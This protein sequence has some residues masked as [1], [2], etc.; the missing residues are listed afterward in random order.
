MAAVAAGGS[1]CSVHASSPRLQRMLARTGNG[2][3]AKCWFSKMGLNPLKLWS[4]VPARKLVVRAAQTK[5]KGV[6][7]GFRA[8][9]FQ[10]FL[11]FLYIVDSLV[12][13]LVWIDSSFNTPEWSVQLPEPL[14]GKVWKLEDFESYPALLVNILFWLSQLFSVMNE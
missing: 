7:L 5:S 6:S 14:T 8:P 12:P 1:M 2:F 4:S 10:V 3:I 13:N 9:D 11:V